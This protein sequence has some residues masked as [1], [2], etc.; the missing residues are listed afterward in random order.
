MHWFMG[1]TVVVHYCPYISTVR[2]LL[3][4]YPGCCVAL[5]HNQIVG[6]SFVILRA[7]TDLGPLMSLFRKQL[8]T[9]PRADLVKH[10]I[11]SR[12]DSRMLLFFLLLFSI[13]FL[14]LVCLQQLCTLIVT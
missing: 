7:S 8:V 3:H 1:K 11:T 14:L 13:L 10:R 6:W 5:T 2:G 12:F 4:V 9:H